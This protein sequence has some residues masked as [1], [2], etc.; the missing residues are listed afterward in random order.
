MVEKQIGKY[1]K[2]LTFDQGGEYSL[3]AFKN[4]CKNN[5]IQQQ[6]TLAQTPQQNGV[7]ESK[8]ITLMESAHSILQGKNIS[9]GFGDDTINIVVYLKKI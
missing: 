1:I 8:D 7:V 9:N 2:I 5:G 4:Y 3:G 6:F